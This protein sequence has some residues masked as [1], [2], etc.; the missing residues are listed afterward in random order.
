M[1]QFRQIQAFY[2]IMTSGTVTQAAKHLG[3]SQPG[4][5]N[6]IANFEHYIGFKLFTRIGGRL[7]PTP[8]A[9]RLFNASEG[10]IE[11]FDQISRR[12]SALRHLQTGKLVIAGL[13]ELSL[14]FLPV[15][16]NQFLVEK[17]KIN[18]SFQTRASVKIQEM[19][20]DHVIETGVTE[21]PVGHDNLN[22]KLFSYPC[23]CVIP[24]DHPL[25]SKKA[26][27]PEDLHEQ[28]LITLGQAHMTYHRLREIF[29]KKNCVWNDRCQARLFSA[30]LVFAR[31][32]MGIALVDPFTIMS[33]NLKNV[34]VK[35]FKPVVSFDLIIIWAKDKP[36]SL[37]GA[38]FIDY[39]TDEMTMAQH[40]YNQP[41][42]QSRI[43]G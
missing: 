33:Q 21:G 31:E 16:I 29:T 20:S 38:S 22:S 7:H 17:P 4:V 41:W 3:I 1:I 13:P 12:A 37:I 35:P 42:F 14:E 15:L 10:V 25:A 6:L 26:L 11:G 5:S 27:T 36:L 30:A 8:E 28:P 9:Q 18:V 39:L 40:A 23:Y 34:V 43:Q 24:R 19:V 2:A 32:G